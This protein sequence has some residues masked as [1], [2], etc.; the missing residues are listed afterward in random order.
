[1]DKEEFIEACKKTE[2]KVHDFFDRIHFDLILPS[3]DEPTQA[4]LIFLNTIREVQP[5]NDFINVIQVKR[6]VLYLF[7]MTLWES[8]R[9]IRTICRVAVAK[10]YGANDNIKDIEMG[11][12][13][14]LKHFK[15]I[16]ISNKFSESY[17]LLIQFDNKK[18][19]D[20]YGLDD[21]INVIYPI[22]I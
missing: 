9:Q 18:K 21:I 3:I 22:K 1:M 19:T 17:D 20:I 4:Q 10:K 2:R 13:I 15:D 5:N 7:G 6:S 8:A 16:K 11:T 14:E 12:L